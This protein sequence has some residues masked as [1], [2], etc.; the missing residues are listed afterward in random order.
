MLTNALEGNLSPSSATGRG[1]P[2]PQGA[3]FFA[4]G[5]KMF[6]KFSAATLAFSV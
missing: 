5:F 4:G 6:L 2:S 3:A 1:L